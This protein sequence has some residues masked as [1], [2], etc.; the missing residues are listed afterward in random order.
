MK[1]AEKVIDA[2]N[3]YVRDNGTGKIVSREEFYEI[4][5]AKYPEVNRTSVYPSDFCYNLYNNGLRYIDDGERCLECVDKGYF[6]ILGTNYKYTGDVFHYMFKENQEV[7]GHW[8]N[9]TYQGYK[10]SYKE[11]Q[12]KSWYIYRIYNICSNKEFSLSYTD[13]FD[14]FKADFI[15]GNIHTRGLDRY[16][17]KDSLKVELLEKTDKLPERMAF[18][19]WPQLSRVSYDENMFEY[20]LVHKFSKVVKNAVD[21]LVSMFPDKNY[22]FKLRVNEEIIIEADVF[23]NEKLTEHYIFTKNGKPYSREII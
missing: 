9:G 4:V 2:I 16:K 12:L 20:S 7:V 23:Y 8:E 13:D 3:S 6:K 22:S 17:Y 1:N 21:G 5:L 11:E 10:K 19:K 15:A 18:Y 14:K